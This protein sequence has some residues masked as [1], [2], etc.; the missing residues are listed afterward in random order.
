MIVGHLSLVLALIISI[1]SAVAFLLG[2]I[3]GCH[4]LCA[5]ARKGVFVVFGLYTVAMATMVYALI[6]NDFSIGLV[7]GGSSRDLQLHYKIGALYSNNTGSLLF[8]GWLISLFTCVLAIEKRNNFPDIIPYALSILIAIQAFFLGMVTVVVNIYERNPLP[9]DDGIGLNPVWQ[10]PA[11]LI[12]PPLLFIGYAGFAVVFAFI[13]GALIAGKSGNNWVLGIRR[14]ALFAWC[15]LGMGNLVGAWW[16]YTESGWGGYWVWDS[17]QNASLMPWLLGTAFLHSIAVQRKRGYLKKWSVFL[18]VS[19]FVFTL[20]GA[21]IT[22]GGM[23]SDLHGFGTTPFVEYLFASTII[24]SL[25]SFVLAIWRREEL[26]NDNDK[27]L[28]L[29]SR[30]GSCMVAN[31]LFTMIVVWVLFLTSYPR[32]SATFGSPVILERN[33]F[34]W[35]C[36]PMLLLMVFCMGIVPLLGWGKSSSRMLRRNLLYSFLGVFLI[37]IVILMSGIGNWYAVAALVCG[38]PLATIF[39]EWFKGTRVYH[40]TSQENYLH[41][42]TSLTWGNK[43]RYGG[44]VAHI[45]IILIALGVIGSSMYG[46]D[47]F[48]TLDLGQSMEIKGYTLTNN[49]LSYDDETETDIYSGQP[50]GKEVVAAEI[51]IY[52]DEQYLKT[53]FPTRNHLVSQNTYQ[54]DS[55]IQ[56]TIIDDLIVRLSGYDL[57]AASASLNVMVNPLVIWIWIGAGI[58]LVG[59]TIAFWPERRVSTLVKKHSQTV[60]EDSK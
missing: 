36:G 25:I 27:P 7:E 40:R 5:S 18:A 50:D 17:V 24:V 45:G 56:T 42:F 57:E 47:K 34:D 48:A 19:T 38:F 21:F 51:T 20:G 44:F 22:H 6:S 49:G 31:M 41:S 43:P 12:H 29:Y 35:G 8:W 54:A 16:A 39:R 4:Q 58:L 52:R 2:A 13:I 3:L 14:W 55:V 15:A 23:D 53:V 26:R 59:G 32:L 33:V 10:N 1:Y 46:V 60:L 9:P 37:V 11:I 28:T 30:E